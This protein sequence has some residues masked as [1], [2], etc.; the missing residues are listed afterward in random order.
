MRG[1]KYTEEDSRDLQKDPPG[2]VHA[3]E[4][5][6]EDRRKPQIR[7]RWSDVS[8]E[9]CQAAVGRIMRSDRVESVDMSGKDHE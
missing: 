7:V 8:G 3:R 9:D 5:T 1:V 4:G 2:S 6:R